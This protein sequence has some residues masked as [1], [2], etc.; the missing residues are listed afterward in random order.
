ML[1]LSLPG[2][3]AVDA[4]LWRGRRR[5]AMIAALLAVHVPLHGLWR[6]FGRRSPWPTSFLRLAGRAAGADVRIVGTPLRSHVLMATNHLTWLDILVLAGASGARFVAKDEIARWPLFGFL[7]GLNR[8]VY[9]ARKKRGEVREQAGLVREALAEGCPVALF[10]E[11]G[12]GDGQGVKPFRASLFEALLPPV[13]GIRLQPVAIDYGRDTPDLAWDRGIGMGREMMR[14]LGLPGRRK[15][16]I[17]FLDPIDPSGWADRKAL[18]IEAR[19]RLVTAME[20]GR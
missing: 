14:V 5:V 8:T 11:G 20:A 4:N 10:A 1:A 2:K 16:T 9:I 3:S 13:P 7:A 19:E 12:T 15:V 18:A 17:R 6:L